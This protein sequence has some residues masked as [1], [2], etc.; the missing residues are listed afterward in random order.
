MKVWEL[1]RDLKKFDEN[2]EV[3]ISIVGDDEFELNLVSSS[4]GRE[5]NR[6]E[7]IVLVA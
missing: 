2:T 3:Y 6:K 4:K 1:I 5:G 7:V